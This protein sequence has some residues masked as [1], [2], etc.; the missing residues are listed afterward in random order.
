MMSSMQALLTLSLADVRHRKLANSLHLILLTLGVAIITALLLISSEIGGRLEKTLAA[1]AGE[2]LR[3]ALFVDV[4]SPLVELCYDIR[5]YIDA[6]HMVTLG[7]EA[8]TRDEAD[9]ASSDDS[10]LHQDF[11]PSAFRNAR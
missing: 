5:V 6:G 2:Q 8:D 9:I 4:R 1:D 3:Q 7:G 11:N 10:D